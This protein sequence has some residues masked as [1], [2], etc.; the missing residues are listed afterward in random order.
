MERGALV[1]RVEPGGAGEAAGF[2]A[3]DVITTIAGRPVQDLHQLHEA[4][5]RHR[6]GEAIGISVWREGQALTLQPVLREES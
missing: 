2:Q 6:A 4:L 1:I 5:S 3:G